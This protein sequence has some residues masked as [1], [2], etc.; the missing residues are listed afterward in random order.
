[1]WNNVHESIFDKPKLDSKVG[2][3]IPGSCINSD[4]SISLSLFKSKLFDIVLSLQ[5][6]GDPLQWHSQNFDVASI[7]GPD[8]SWG[9]Q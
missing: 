5:S 8:W 6:R 7:K 3:V 1:M 4:L 9:L 2:Y